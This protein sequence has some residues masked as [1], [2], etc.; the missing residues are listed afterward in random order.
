VTDVRREPARNPAVVAAAEPRSAAGSRPSAFQGAVGGTAL[1]VGFALLLVGLD[2]PRLATAYLPV[3]SGLGL[4]VFALLIR[5]VGPGLAWASLVLASLSASGIPIDL[6]READ[7]GSSGIG[8]WLVAAV[9]AVSAAIFTVTLAAIYA[10]RPERRLTGAVT[11]VAMLVVAWFIAACLL[12]IGLIV[13][14]NAAPDDALTWIDVATLPTALYV[15]LVLLLLAFGALGAVRAATIRA[16][17]RAAVAGARGQDDTES[18]LDRMAGVLRELL[19]GVDPGD[20]AVE[21]ERTRLAGDLHAAVLPAL[22]RA[23]VEVEAGGPPELLAE[24]LKTIDVELERVMAD[25]WPVVLDTFGLVS[26]LEELAE[27]L[28][29]ESGVTVE[30]AVETDDGRPPRHVERAA[31]RA[32]QLALDNAVRHAAAALISVRVETAPAHLAVTVSDDGR[33]FDVRDAAGRPGRGLADLE[34]RADSVGGRASVASAIGHGTT[35]TFAWP[36]SS[37]RG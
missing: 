27:R 35:V 8:E 28:E 12:V 13:T 30:L 14:G 31:W 25:R 26:A 32:V 16:D 22:R 18:A 1:V 4:L 10:T 24:R 2:L 34:R 17:A 3:L 5:K 21:A 33:G 23:I 19:P 6:A 29:R 9:R 11:S 7:P 20:A 37:E 36:G 15:D